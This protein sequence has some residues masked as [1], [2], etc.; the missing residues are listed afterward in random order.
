MDTKIIGEFLKQLRKEYNMT[1]EQL[2]EKIGVTNKTISRWETGTYMPPIECLKLLS[3]LYQ[4]SINEILAG[5]RIENGNCT[6]IADINLTNVLKEKQK[7]RKEFEVKMTIII[8]V[9]TVIANVIIYLLPL[10]SVKDIVI[11]ILVLV[12]TMLNNVISIV[13]IVTNK[14]K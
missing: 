4:I 14:H 5:K 12:M 2:G 11:F 7:E 3:E 1:Q 8:I 6:E 10:D 9:S 13:A